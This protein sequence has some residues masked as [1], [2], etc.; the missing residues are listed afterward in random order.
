M[1]NY[2]DR[3]GYTLDTLSNRSIWMLRFLMLKKLSVKHRDVLNAMKSRIS[4]GESLDK[5]DCQI[6]SD[7]WMD[8]KKG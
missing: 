6:L 2:L 3:V 7:I 4:S 5:T 8:I 1:K